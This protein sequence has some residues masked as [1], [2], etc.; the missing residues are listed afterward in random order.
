[1]TLEDA[2]TLIDQ[3]R[4]KEAAYLEEKAS[5]RAEIGRLTTAVERLTRQ[6]D[7][8]LAKLGEAPRKQA[9]DEA[10]K[11]EGGDKPSKGAPPV[12]PRPPKRHNH[13]RGGI[14]DD[15]PDNIERINHPEDCPCGGKF[16]TNGTVENEQ[17]DF[18]RSHV[19]RRRIIRVLGRCNHCG[20]RY[21]PPL[22]PMPMEHA[23]C[24]FEMMAWVLYAKVALHLPLD[25]QRREF[26]LQGA[27]IST[28]MITR[29]FIVGTDLLRVVV[30]QIRL[31][32]LA[33]K[34]LRM[35]GTGI[36]VLDFS[37]KGKPAPIGHVTVYCAGACVVYHYSPNKKGEH[38]EDFLTL[39]MKQDGT[40]VLWT[41]TITADAESA[42]DRLFKDGERIEAGCNAHG[43]RKFRDDADVAPLLADKALSFIDRF[44]KAEHEAKDLALT[45]EA[46]LAYRQ[47]HAGPASLEFRAWLDEHIGELLPSNPVRKAMQYYINHWPALTRFLVDPKVPLDN[48]QSENALRKLVVGRKNW[49]FAGGP[50][51]AV[52]VCDDLSVIESCKAEGVDPYEYLVWVLPKL[53]S[54]AENRGLNVADL[55]PSAYKRRLIEKK[56]P[57][58]SS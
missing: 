37:S 58:D 31:E 5:M 24:T 14:P 22:P 47:E 25:R 11:T 40:K 6:L 7:Q 16:Q 38:A 28:A 3:L 12:N 19:R 41:G 4:A 18:V 52:R 48:N 20:R 54:H 26:N 29:W 46:L 44:Y 42:H 15:L 55:T 50:D 1:M 57:G 39:E 43:L 36:K 51:G 10:G 30:A 13:G 49:L 27:R 35:D 17:Y 2:L 9:S 45:D 21:T 56:G 8:L 34:H 53:V 33:G 32:I 23:S